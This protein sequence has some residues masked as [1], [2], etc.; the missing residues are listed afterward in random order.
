[1]AD[2]KQEVAAALRNLLG[3]SPTQDLRNFPSW[4]H[5]YELALKGARAPKVF[6]GNDYRYRATDSG[7]S[8]MMDLSWYKGFPTSITDAQI[9]YVFKEVYEGRHVMIGNQ[10]TVSL[11]KVDGNQLG[12]EAATACNDLL[13]V[14]VTTFMNLSNVFTRAAG[15]ECMSGLS[16]SIGHKGELLAHIIVGYDKGG[17]APTDTEIMDRI[18][19]TKTVHVQYNKYFSKGVGFRVT[20]TKLLSAF[21]DTYLSEERLPLLAADGYSSGDGW[22]WDAALK[23]VA[24]FL[25]EHGD[26]GREAVR[27]VL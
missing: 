3:P 5:L 12:T 11:P 15:V 18:A 1:M 26:G 27:K 2:I 10:L 24:L 16:V 4:K 8:L 19:Y 9:L 22:S 6:V 13:S 14:Q 21:L 7:R 25:L 20:R 17:E 23:K